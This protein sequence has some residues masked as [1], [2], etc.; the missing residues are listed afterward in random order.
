MSWVGHNGALQR[1][2]VTKFYDRV[3]VPPLPKQPN[4]RLVWNKEDNSDTKTTWSKLNFKVTEKFKFLKACPD[5][6]LG[7]IRNNRCQDIE[8]WMEPISAFQLFGNNWIGNAF[9]LMI[10]AV[11]CVVNRACPKHQKNYCI[12]FSFKRKNNN[13][14]W[15]YDYHVLNKLKLMWSWNNFHVKSFN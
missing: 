14:N 11:T 13:S 10:V 6:Y 1:H 15:C 12:N 5:R 8:V 3:V 7:R 4:F 9:K 2:I